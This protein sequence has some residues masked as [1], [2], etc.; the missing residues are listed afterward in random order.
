MRRV[1]EYLSASTGAR[2]ELERLG[3]LPAE[4]LVGAKVAVLGSLEVDGLVEVE[5]TDDD[6]GTEVEVLVNDVNELG[7][8]LLG[9]AV[10]VDVDGE[11]LGDTN[12]VRELDESTAG[13]AG[14]NQRLGD[15]ARSVGGRAIDLG[16]I[17]A[18]EGTTTV[19]TP[20][21]VGVDDDLTAG[22]TGITLRAADDELAGGLN[23][24][25]WWSAYTVF[26]A[27]V[28]TIGLTW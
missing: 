10:G 15:P 11:G 22:Q 19:G 21:T 24:V 28:V 13:E 2:L 7:R 17:L 9:G 18:G 1:V 27:Q 12:G 14:G 5:G 20:A 8:G 4:V 25:G 3:L 26:C 6:T 23:L 16:E